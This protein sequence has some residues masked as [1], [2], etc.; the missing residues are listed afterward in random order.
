MLEEMNVSSQQPRWSAEE[1]ARRGS[2]IYESKIRSLV[3]PGN[4]G[5]VVAIDIDTEDYAVADTALKASDVLFAKHPD[6]EIWFVR[7][8]HRELRLIGRQTWRATP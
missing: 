4:E 2:A 6:A 7:I 8:G 3:E 5:K 1:T